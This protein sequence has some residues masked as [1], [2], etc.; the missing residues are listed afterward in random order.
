MDFIEHRS[1]EGERWDQLAWRYYGDACLYQ[2]IL[3][4]NP[5]LRIL[6]SLAGGLRVRIPILDATTSDQAAFEDLPPWKR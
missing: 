4:A 3:D 5:Q 1:A 6:P 2:P